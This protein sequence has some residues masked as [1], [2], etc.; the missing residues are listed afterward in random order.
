MTGMVSSPRRGRIDTL[1]VA[2]AVAAIAVVA[3]HSN[4]VANA[5]YA[6]IP[7]YSILDLGE[8]G[9]DFFF[10]LSGFIMMYSGGRF[11]GEKKEFLPFVRRR[12]L[13]LYPVL[14]VVVVLSLIGNLLI[15]GQGP[16]TGTLVTSLT[17]LP[18]LDVPNP[19][20]I[21]T[22]RHEVMFYALF[23]LVIL[24]RKAGGALIGLWFVGIAFQTVQHL[25]G[26]AG[27]TGLYAF[28]FS[29]INLQFFMGALIG[30]IYLRGYQVN[31]LLV[32]TLG[33]TALVLFSALTVYAGVPTREVFDYN[34]PHE[35]LWDILFGLAFMVVVLGLAELNKNTKMLSLLVFLGAASYAIYLVHLPVMG[36]VGRLSANIVPDFITTVGGAQILLMIAAILAG[37]LLHIAFEQPFAKLARTYFFP[38]PAKTAPQDNL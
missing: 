21:W 36:L 22:L 37:S 28:V 10:V 20:V 13:R 2:R 19:P 7:T 34:V 4:T 14:W 29:P 30:W 11:L 17:L 31:G 6:D 24:S 12:F 32:F 35:A 15:D 38:R 5:N 1:E 23:A 9:V 26:Q 18:S 33:L 8:R 27:L 25:S 16:K 3:F